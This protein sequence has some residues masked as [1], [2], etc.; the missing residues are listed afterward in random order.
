[1]A[2]EKH[3]VRVSQTPATIEITD[4]MT[5]PTVLRRIARENQ[6]RVVIEK[7]SSI[8]TWVPVT[9]REF[10]SEV[11][12]LARGLIALGVNQ[13]D[14]VAIMCRTRYEY[15]VV[16]MALLSVGAMS[17]SIYETDSTEQ[18]RWIIDDAHVRFAFAESEQIKAVLEPVQEAAP[19]F[20]RTFVIDEG[21][22]AQISA[23]GSED[24]DRELD[25]RIDAG[26]AS[27]LM[28]IIYTSGTTGRP[29][30]VQ[31]THRNML[32]LSI[33]GPLDPDL[34]PVCQ[35][36]K[37][38]LLV[39]P[40][41]HVFARFFNLVALFAGN[42]IGYVPDTKSL[43]SDLQTFRPDYMIL[44]P[45]VFEKLY[46]AA[47]AQAGHGIA[48]KTFRYFARVAIAYSRAMDTPEGPSAALRVQHQIGDKLVYHR[49]RTILG[50]HMTHAICGGAPLGE[51]LGHFFRGIGLIVMEGWGLTETNGPATVNSPRRMRIGSVGPAFPG[52]MVTTD[53]DG[54]ILVKGE[55]V[56]S[57]YNNNEK[58]TEE[59]FT[60]DGFFR[61]GDLGYVD[62]DG[63]VWVT[64][65]KKELIVTAGGKNVSPAVLEDRLRG[66]PLVS[67]VVVVGDQKPF[68]AALVTLDEEMLPQWLKN[69]GLP[70]MSVSDAATN[71]AVLASLERGV[72][73]ANQVVSRAESIRKFRVLTTDF[74]ISNGYM[75]PSLKVK[76]AAVLKNF[77][78]EIEKLYEGVSSPGQQN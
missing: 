35:R 8:N 21:A 9:W 42:P 14:R 74:T 66:H 51:R 24:L 3:D 72:Q 32:H 57:A 22:I 5:I 50:G 63:F 17:I 37:R 15:T 4:S 52:T 55:S 78:G 69:H 44:V 31:I 49:I 39:L 38:T 64:G 7:K 47:D 26:R 76:R 60:P 45:R 20:E 28:T 30:G 11:R 77:A 73:R 23:L 46:N 34:A 75:S 61:T 29:K 36:G 65:R 59:S 1:M 13:G 62:D 25:R 33:N 48:L 58:A 68:I 19:W 41:S 70:A 27:D 2:V 56:F 67:Q 18:A 71:P 10:Y 16:D 40:M 43:V 12:A 53:E 54:E 6:D